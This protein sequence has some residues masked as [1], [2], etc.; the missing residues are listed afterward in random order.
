MSAVGDDGPAADTPSV[1]ARVAAAVLERAVAEDPRRRFATIRA[2]ATEL[3]G[4]GGRDAGA[5]MMFF[6]PPAWPP[7]PWY[8]RIDWRLVAAAVAVAVLFAISVNGEWVLSAK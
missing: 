8:S 1:L 6:E 3:A 2:L 4:L 7:P 5:A